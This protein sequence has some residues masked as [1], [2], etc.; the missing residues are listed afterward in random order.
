MTN[1]Y[2]IEISYP[3]ETVELIIHSDDTIEYVEGPLS[4]QTFQELTTIQN[5]QAGL[6][7]WM[8]TANV[9]KIEVKREEES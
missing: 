3:E 9:S 1:Q 5:I 6:I 8:K 2:R 7:V 4:D